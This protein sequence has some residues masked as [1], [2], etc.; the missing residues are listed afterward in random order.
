MNGT[1]ARAV[2][3]SLDGERAIAYHVETCVVVRDR[4]IVSC[5][6]KFASFCDTPA[7]ETARPRI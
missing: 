2:T 4:H 7:S 6:R 5:R 1:S 3:V